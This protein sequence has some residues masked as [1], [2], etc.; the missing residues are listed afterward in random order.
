MIQ[1][2]QVKFSDGLDVSDILV[3]LRNLLVD[4]VFDSGL[5]LLQ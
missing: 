1:V 4:F 2:F 3:S 5:D